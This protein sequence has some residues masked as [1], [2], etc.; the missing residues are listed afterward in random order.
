MIAEIESPQSPNRQG[1]DP[2]TIEEVMAYYKVL[3]LSVAVIKDFA[4]HWAKSWGVAD[5]KTGTPATNETLYQA[6]SISKPVAAVRDPILARISELIYSLFEAGLFDGGAACGTRTSNSPGGAFTRRQFRARHPSSGSDVLPVATGNLVGLGQGS[7]R[8]GYRHLAGLVALQAHLL[9][10]LGASEAVALPDNL[11]Q[12]VAFRAGARWRSAS[13]AGLPAWPGS[14]ALEHVE[15]AQHRID[16]VELL[17][18]HLLLVQQFLSLLQQ[19]LTLPGDERFS[20]CQHGTLHV[21][22][23]VSATKACSLSSHGSKENCSGKYDTRHP[24]TINQPALKLEKGSFTP[25]MYLLG[26]AL[27][28]PP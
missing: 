12:L 11:Q 21:S 4:V 24:R 2:L 19:R 27:P 22:I 3:G 13:A 5:V 28:A 15:L 18:Q 16:F 25:G 20:F 26:R 6:A 7:Q 9:Q 17:L 1:A 23:S 14:F 10:D 8:V